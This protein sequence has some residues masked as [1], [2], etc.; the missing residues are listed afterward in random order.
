MQFGQLTGQLVV[1]CEIRSE[2][3]VKKKLFFVVSM[4]LISRRRSFTC[5]SVS[6]SQSD[7]YLTCKSETYLHI[8]IASMTWD[9]VRLKGSDSTQF[10]KGDRIGTPKSLLPLSKIVI[11]SPIDLFGHSW[12]LI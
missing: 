9:Q 2:K 8:K 10:L 12:T 3:Q 4:S 1:Y 5:K 11:S 6:L 7:S